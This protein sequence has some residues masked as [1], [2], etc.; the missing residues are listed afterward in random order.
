M[1]NSPA[2]TWR[3]AP[4]GGGPEQGNSAG[5][6]YFVN[7]AVTKMVREILQNSLDH[8]TPG[9]DTIDII[10]RLHPRQPR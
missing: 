5:Q 9:N 10:F 4:T 3:F 8:P 1:T 7:D 2:F 6:H